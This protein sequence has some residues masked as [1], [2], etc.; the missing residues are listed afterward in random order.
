MIYP[1][2]L[3]VYIHLFAISQNKFT[4]LTQTLRTKF[5]LFQMKRTIFALYFREGMRKRVYFLCDA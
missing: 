5:I 1:I 4:P 2:V 3:L